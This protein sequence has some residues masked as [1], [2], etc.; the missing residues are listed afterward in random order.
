MANNSNILYLF[1]RPTEPLFME[2]GSDGSTVTFDIPE[3]YY[4]SLITILCIEILNQSINLKKKNILRHSQI[5]LISA[6]HT[7]V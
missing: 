7:G 3:D 6:P 5:I 4:V 2:K 1:D